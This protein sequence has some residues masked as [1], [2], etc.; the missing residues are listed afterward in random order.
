MSTRLKC[1]NCG[2]VNSW[3]DPTCR[4]C[5]TELNGVPRIPAPEGKI[6]KIGRAGGFGLVLWG[7]L[8]ASAPWLIVRYLVMVSGK[9]TAAGCVVGLPMVLFGAS[10]IFVPF[11]GVLK[12]HRRTVSCLVIGIGFG[13]IEAYFFGR[14]LD[15]W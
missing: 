7:L 10:C 1:L 12:D 14:Y 15:L 5:G 11:E 3:N 8:L 4:R 13:F 6:V 9:A 2:L